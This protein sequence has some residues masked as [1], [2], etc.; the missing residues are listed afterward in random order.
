VSDIVGSQVYLPAS[1]THACFRARQHRSSNAAR[2]NYGE[3]QPESYLPLP[4]LVFEAGVEVSGTVLL[5]L[6]LPAE[7]S[8]VPPEVPLVSAPELPPVVPA[9][10]LNSITKTMGLKHFIIDRSRKKVKAVRMAYAYRRN[11]LRCK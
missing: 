1:V 7:P 4:G 2:L 9:H 8:V 3:L 10:A 6:L 5:G 11:A